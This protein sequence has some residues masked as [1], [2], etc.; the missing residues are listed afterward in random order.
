MGLDITA[1]KNLIK[2]V[3]DNLFDED[4]ELNDW[5]NHFQLH[6]NPHY[7][8]RASDISDGCVYSSGES[9]GFRAGSY[10]GYNGWREELARLAGY[11]FVK[12]ESDRHGFSRGAW[13]SGEGPFWEIINFSDCGGVIGSEVSKKLLKDFCDFEEK[14]E[15]HESD[16]FKRLYKE[17]RGAF[18]LASNNGCVDFH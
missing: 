4:G 10:G 12:G 17:W 3:G 8:D 1:H 18:E 11:E 13:N 14:A 2:V 15:G 9:L 5:D 7:P 6:I 16:N